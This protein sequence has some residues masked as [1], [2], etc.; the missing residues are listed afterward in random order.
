[1]THLDK[2]NEIQQLFPYLIVR[3]AAAAIDYYK[4][5]FGAEETMRLCEPSGRIG[6]AML[7]FGSSV[8]MLSDEYP[9]RGVQ[10]PLAHGGAGSFLHL[11]VANVDELTARAVAAGA[12]IIYEPTT[13]FYGERSSKIEDPF[14]HIW[15]LGQHI[16]DV[17]PE[18]MQRRY[19]ELL[20][21]IK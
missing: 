1:M 18:E 11:H 6:H 20:S 15:M 4:R 8:V 14:G 17:S 16:E 7:N 2:T 19:T 5:V 12:K 3:D 21:Q 9:E 10:S 13:Q